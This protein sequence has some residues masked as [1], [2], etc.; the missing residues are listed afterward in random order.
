MPHLGPAE[1]APLGEHVTVMHDGAR[2]F[3]HL[4]VHVIGDDQIGRSAAP[5]LAAHICHD[6]FHSTA[7]KPIIGV[8]H[9]EVQTRGVRQTGVHRLPMTAVFLVDG[10][11]DA[12]MK[13]LP[14]IGLFRG[15]VFDRP[16][17]DDDDLDVI[18]ALIAPACK[19]GL[20]ALIHI[21]RGVIARDGEGDAFH[22]C[23][24]LETTARMRLE[25][26]AVHMVRP[27][28]YR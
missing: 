23:P 28:F 8:D 14:A 13:L 16:I 19:D 15:V 24:F 6:V 17:V 9:L 18:A 3:V 22:A 2:A 21:C 20:D 7:V 4:L 11:D 27:P 26:A 1:F 25:N 5:D 12:R 10:L